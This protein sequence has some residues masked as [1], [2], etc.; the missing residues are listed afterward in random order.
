MCV[1]TIILVTHIALQYAFQSP[2]IWLL[3]TSR[4]I[5]KDNTTNSKKKQ[6]GSDSKQY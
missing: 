4:Q 1:I 6:F 5:P 3:E 2:P